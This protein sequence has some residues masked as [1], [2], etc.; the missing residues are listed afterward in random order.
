[1]FAVVT[2]YVYIYIYISSTLKVCLDDMFV[3]N[4]HLELHNVHYMINYFLQ[5]LTAPDVL[6]STSQVP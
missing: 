1:M 6:A 3:Y 2:I 4:I 5:R